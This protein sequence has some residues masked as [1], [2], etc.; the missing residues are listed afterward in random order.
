MKRTVR[1]AVAALA[2]SAL[3]AQPVAAN[4]FPAL[5]PLYAAGVMLCSAITANKLDQ[6]DK[7]KKAGDHDRS[8]PLVLCAVPVVGMATAV[9]DKK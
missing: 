6:D 1:A 5:I 9:S 2:F 4:A 7:A 3:I 8:E